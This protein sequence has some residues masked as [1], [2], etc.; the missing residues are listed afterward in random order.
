[1]NW[2]GWLQNFC[3]YDL[4]PGTGWRFSGQQAGQG[5]P[6]PPCPPTDPAAGQQSHWKL[7]S[8]LNFEGGA[9]HQEEAGDAEE[10]ADL[11]NKPTLPKE[12]KENNPQDTGSE[13]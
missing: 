8:K 11:E 5:L 3:W 12:P 2:T 7:Y 13:N 6:A 4:P 9:G 1:M 10:K